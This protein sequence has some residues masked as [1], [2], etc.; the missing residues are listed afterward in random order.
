MKYLTVVACVLVGVLAA[1]KYTDK[2]D[3]INLQ[4]ILNNDR[5]LRAYIDCVLYNGKCTA[6]G[7]TLKENLKDGLETGCEKCTEKQEEGVET[8]VEFL[9]ESKPEIWE[10]VTKVLDPTGKYRKK[11]EDRAAAKGIKIPPY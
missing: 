2:Y 9:I 7:Q 6:E 3:N 5:F 11:Y 8:T 4:E 1:D 10:E